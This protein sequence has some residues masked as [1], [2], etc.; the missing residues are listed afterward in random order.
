[1]T[2]DDDGLRRRSR[3]RHPVVAGGVGFDRQIERRHLR[4]KPFPRVAPH[5]APRDALGAV[6]CGGTRR[7]LAQI[8][9]DAA[10]RIVDG[11]HSVLNTMIG[12]TFVARRTGPSAATTAARPNAPAA[13]A[14]TAGSVALTPKSSVRSACD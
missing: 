2:A 9:D 8:R 7:E 5:R 1:M 11:R 6:G 13:I 4:A 10:R 14:K 3:Q 12:S